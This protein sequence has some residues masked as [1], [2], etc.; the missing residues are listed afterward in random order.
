MDTFCNASSSLECPT[1]ATL[2]FG[3]RSG[4]STRHPEKSW[5]VTKALGGV[6]GGGI[7]DAVA[8]FNDSDN[9]YSTAR[10]NV[11]AY[12]DVTLQALMLQH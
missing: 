7:E 3:S 4:K 12:D 8:G 1:K 11:V 5:L 10:E 2:R 9:C 6:H